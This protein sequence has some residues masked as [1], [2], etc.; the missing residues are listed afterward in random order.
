MATLTTQVVTRAGITPTYAAATGGGDAMAC[1]TDIMLHIKNAAAATMTVTLA[2]PSG[3]S[4]YPN[5]AYTSTAVAVPNAGE[6]MIGPIQPPIYQD[7]T[8]G[9]CTIT[10]T[11]TASVTVAAINLQEP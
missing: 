11:T 3:S 2:I 10:Y 1:N 5:V 7:P 9:L 4:G 8:T 6:K